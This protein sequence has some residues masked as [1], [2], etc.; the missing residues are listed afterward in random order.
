MLS[1]LN[2]I[3]RPVSNC[4]IENFNLLLGISGIRMKLE[5]LFWEKGLFTQVPKL[6][7][8]CLPP[9]PWI[10]EGFFQMCDGCGCLC[11]HSMWEQA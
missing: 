10:K 4:R 9:P 5:D 8:K 11:V 1:L 3:L 2:C 6:L 7:C